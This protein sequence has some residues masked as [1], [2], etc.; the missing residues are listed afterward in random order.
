[1]IIQLQEID[2]LLVEYISRTLCKI[3]SLL[4]N[5]LSNKKRQRVTL[6]Q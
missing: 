1:M 5:L 4:R 6:R 2:S 3:F